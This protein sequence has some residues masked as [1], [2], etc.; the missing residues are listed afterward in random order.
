[1]KEDDFLIFNPDT[2]WNK[3]YVIEIN[4]MIEFILKKNLN[5]ILLL[6]NKKLSFDKNLNGDFNLKII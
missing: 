5:N 2:I 3:K 1:M 6:V 4:N